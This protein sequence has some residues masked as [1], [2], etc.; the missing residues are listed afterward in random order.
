MGKER[1]HNIRPNDARKQPNIGG[2]IQ[3]F[4]YYGRYMP[5]AFLRYVNLMLR[6]W[7]KNVLPTNR[8]EREA[9]IALPK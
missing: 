9:F 1:R 2:V 6:A 5:S 4:E 7:A 8:F 3:P